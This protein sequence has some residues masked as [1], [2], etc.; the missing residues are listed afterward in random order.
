MISVNIILANLFISQY[1]E[2]T[3]SS[4]SLRETGGTAEVNNQILWNEVLLHA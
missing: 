4:S 1:A 3:T 2:K